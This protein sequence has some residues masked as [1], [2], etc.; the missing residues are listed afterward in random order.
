MFAVNFLV[1]L[2]IYFLFLVMVI[3]ILKELSVGEEYFCCGY[4]I[5]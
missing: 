2:L 5:E 4:I 1:F 3:L